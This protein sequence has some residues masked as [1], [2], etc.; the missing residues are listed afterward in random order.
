M[1]TLSQKILQHFSTQTSDD[2]EKSKLENLAKVNLL[3]YAIYPNHL[4]D[5]S[6][7]KKDP[8]EYDKWRQKGFN[9]VELLEEFPALRPNACL[10]LTQ[11][12]K[13]QPR[14]YSI[15]SSPKLEKNNIHIT[16]G[17]VEYNPEGRET[18]YGV[19]SK[20]LDDLGQNEQIPMFVRG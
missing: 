8:L 19:C 16:L 20:W 1:S 10:L 14:F 17:V 11:L 7:F 12:P 15:S 18:R 9:L 3:S 13:L 6:I 5:F 2:I 4:I